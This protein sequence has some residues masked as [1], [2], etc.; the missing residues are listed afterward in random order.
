M[1]VQLSCEK[2]IYSFSKN[3]APIVR[4]TAPARVEIETYDCFT[5]QVTSTE[6][7]TSLDWDRINPATGP[8]EV[9]DAEP[10]DILKVHIETI[11]WAEQGIMATGPKMGVMGHRLQKLSAKPIAIRDGKAIFNEQLHIPLNPMIGVI[12]VA[13]AEGEV[14]C[15]TPGSHGGNMDNKLITEGAT[16]YFPVF[17]KG[18]LFG[19]GDLHAAMGDGEVCVSGIEIP[20]KVTVQLDVIKGFSIPNP[21][22]ENADSFVTIASASTLDEAAKTAVEEMIDYLSQYIDLP[23]EELT[24]LMS[25]TGQTEICQMVDPLVTARFVVPKWVLKSYQVPIYE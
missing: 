3:H 22:L 1:T 16:L 8:I 15:G 5:N 6:T 25:A 23:L 17:V 14:P 7:F 20:G 2:S 4:V 19:L 10:G 11:E 9:E 24:M 18:A 12:G 21:R 13:P